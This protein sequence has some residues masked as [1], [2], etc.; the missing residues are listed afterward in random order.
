VERWGERGAR[1]DPALW[2]ARLPVDEGAV[3]AEHSGAPRTVR[4]GMRVG[5]LLGV[6][7]GVWMGLRDA[8][9]AWSAGATADAAWALL[10]GIALVG[11]AGLL[12]GIALG[13][14]VGVAIGAMRRD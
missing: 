14:G 11:G 13:A 12:L 1:S 7:P 8:S 3:V 9:R 5:A 10:M 4:V 2:A 6:F